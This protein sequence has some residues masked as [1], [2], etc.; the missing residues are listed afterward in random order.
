LKLNKQMYLDTKLK[1][2]VVEEEKKTD[3]AQKLA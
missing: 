2:N 1:K 3:E